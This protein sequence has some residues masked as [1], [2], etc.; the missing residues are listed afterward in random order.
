MSVCSECCVVRY[1]SLRRADPSS[2]GVLPTVLCLH[3]CDQ[4]SL[5]LRR[6]RPTRAVEPWDGKN[7]KA[8]RL[9]LKKQRKQSACPSSSG[10]SRETCSGFKVFF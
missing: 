4:E 5:N 7:H 2:S 1:R 3:K 10:Y 8:H 6:P 9:S